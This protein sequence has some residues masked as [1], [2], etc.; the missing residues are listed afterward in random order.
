MLFSLFAC[1]HMVVIHEIMHLR[2]NSCQKA[3]NKNIIAYR[4]QTSECEKDTASVTYDAYCRYMAD[5]CETDPGNAAYNA[6]CVQ[7]ITN[8]SL[9]DVTSTALSTYS[10]NGWR[11]DLESSGEKSLS[12]SITI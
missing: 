12:S 9:T 6:Q 2:H 8:S 7:K 4:F 1:E 11:L 10:A 5:S 3:H